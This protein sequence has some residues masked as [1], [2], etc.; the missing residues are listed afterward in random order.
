MRFC[1]LAIVLAIF[2]TGSFSIFG[3]KRE[4]SVTF[5]DL[6]TAYGASLEAK[7]KLTKKLIDGMRTNNVPAIGFVNEAKLYERGETD[8]RIALL[9]TWL[10]AGL[11]LGNHTF[12]HINNAKVSLAAYQDDIVR[13]ET[14]T[15]R[16]LAEKQLK[17]R[18]FRHPFLF[19]GSTAEYKLGIEQFLTAR[20]YTIAPV[21]IDNRDYIFARL[22][23][24]ALDRKDASA[25][26]RIADAYVPYMEKM[27]EF[28]ETVSRDSLGYEPKQILLLHANELN[29]DRFGELVGMIKKRGYKFIPLEEA[30][31]DKA[32]QLPEAQTEKGISWLHRWMMAKGV[33]LSE[34]PD[35]PEFIQ[36]LFKARRQ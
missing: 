16:L 5:D 8:A 28:F 35:E 17:P 20:G 33:K 27:F 30:L 9:Q 2:I 24:D 4:V 12:S 36:Q 6:P 10:D 31:K 11:E 13:G 19:T 25:A 34:E 29:A 23:R 22:Y 18:Y 14:V 1:K 7:R 21:T 3:Q 15:R 32:Y 26:K